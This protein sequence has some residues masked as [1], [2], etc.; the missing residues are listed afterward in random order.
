MPVKCPIARK[1]AIFNIRAAFCWTHLSF[2]NFHYPLS[3][4]ARGEGIQKCASVKSLQEIEMRPL[5]LTRL[6]ERSSM[7]ANG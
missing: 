5:L 3:P 7:I 2:C 4:L 6:K 1:K